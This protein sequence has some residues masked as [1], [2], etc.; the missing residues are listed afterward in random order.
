MHA[1]SLPPIKPRSGE[2]IFVILSS[3]LY[4][5]F[6]DDVYPVFLTDDNEEMDLFAFINHADPTKDANV[7]HVVQDEEFHVDAHT[8]RLRQ[9]LL[10]R[11]S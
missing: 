5:V 10:K 2:T 6:D 1:T 11:G 8:R 9:L 7:A 3:E 4:Y